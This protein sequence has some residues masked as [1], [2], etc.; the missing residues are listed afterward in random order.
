MVIQKELNTLI[1][2]NRKDG[3]TLSFDLCRDEEYSDIQAKLDDVSF[4]K[5]ITGINCLFNA[6]W[7]A[8][9]V[10]V[11]FRNIKYD[12]EKVKFSKGGVEK[13]VGEKIIC[14]ADDVRLT[15]LVYYNTCP[16]IARIELKKIGKQRYVP[17]R[18]KTN[19]T[20]RE[21]DI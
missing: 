13:I 12:V 19:G 6:F 21:E 20:N 17:V 15:V 3:K 14:H 11:N 18:G 9:T 5:D 2:V 16:K 1:K 7:H 10:P 4:S 8:I